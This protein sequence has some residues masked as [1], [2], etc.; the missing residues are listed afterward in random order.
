M[1]QTI[2]R[3]TGSVLLSQ[4]DDLG[5]RAAGLLEPQFMH[6]KNGCDYSASPRVSAGIMARAQEVAI[7]NILSVIINSAHGEG[8]SG[9]QGSPHYH[10]SITGMQGLGHSPKGTTG[11]CAKG[12]LEFRTAEGKCCLVFL[13]SAHLPRPTQLHGNW[14]QAS[15]LC[16]PLSPGQLPPLSP[17]LSPCPHLLTAL[18]L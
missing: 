6:L 2:G 14:G 9:P 1:K 12:L 4:L 5:Q 3:V 7:L 18:A 11:T 17:C 8:E 10:G 16:S 15:L 13:T